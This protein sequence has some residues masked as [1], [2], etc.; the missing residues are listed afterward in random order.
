MFSAKNAKFK[1][2]QK[3][4]KDTICEHNCANCFCQNVR[5]FCIFIFAVFQYPFLSEMFFD[6]FPKIEKYKKKTKASKTKH[7][8]ERKTKD[9]KQKQ[10]K[11]YDSKQ[12]KTTSRTTE[13]KEQLKIR[14]PTK[15]KGKARTRNKN[16]KQKGR[17]R[18]KNKRET[19]KERETENGESETRLKRNKGRHR[20]NTQKCPFWGGKQGFF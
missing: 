17:K 16:E 14:K 3:R 20:K 18:E 13:T 15:Q 2:T 9:A 12:S 11:Y 7:K 4:K 6:W 5:F 10:M 1:E 8:N 19:K